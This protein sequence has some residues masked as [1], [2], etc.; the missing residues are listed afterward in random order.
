MQS[1]LSRRA[2]A[3]IRASP[4]ADATRYPTPSSNSRAAITGRKGDFGAFKTPTLRNLD[5]T[6]PYM[7]D[8][9]Q[10]SL[11]EV[12]DYF[13]RGGQPDARLS[14]LMRPLGLTANERAD[15]VAFLKSLDG[16]RVALPEPETP[17][18]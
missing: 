9:S 2:S 14:P 10:A 4:R 12:L 15:L 5:D 1:G 6:A 13:D 17:P 16:D 11:T 18:Q 8:G 3:A 7:H